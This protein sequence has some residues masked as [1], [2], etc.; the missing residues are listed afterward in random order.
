MPVIIIGNS[1]G[2]QFVYS[3]II[4]FENVYYDDQTLHFSTK[5]HFK[6][7][8]NSFRYIIVFT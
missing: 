1:I 3:A 6:I 2:I 7:V 4:P 8:E 5:N